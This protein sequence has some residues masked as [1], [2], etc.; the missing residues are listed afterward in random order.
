MQL[1]RALAHSTLQDINGLKRSGRFAGASSPRAQAEPSQD[2]SL[3][4][5]PPSPHS[6]W[7]QAEGA[8]LASYDGKVGRRDQ[9]FPAEV[10]LL[11]CG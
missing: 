3:L 1:L 9:E 4:L 6:L 10:L 5:A 7:Q 11:S 2:W 8:S